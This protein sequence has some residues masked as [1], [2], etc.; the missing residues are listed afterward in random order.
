MTCFFLFPTP[1]FLEKCIIKALA[2]APSCRKG[3]L[4][5]N[6]SK[7][8]CAC[9]SAPEKKEAACVLVCTGELYGNASVRKKEMLFFP[10]LSLEFAF[11]CTLTAAFSRNSLLAPSGQRVRGDG[12]V[13][14]GWCPCPFCYHILGIT[15]LDLYLTVRFIYQVLESTGFLHVT[16]G[17]S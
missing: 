10:S 5:V 3:Y 16:Y 8:C 1:L 2:A 13:W 17:R 7:I 12:W 6:N 11:K 14:W 15:A 4:V 9:L